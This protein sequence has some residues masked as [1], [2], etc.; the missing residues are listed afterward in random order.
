MTDRKYQF[1]PL[2]T[3][4]DRLFGRWVD[5][6]R[7]EVIREFVWVWLVVSV[8]YGTRFPAETRPG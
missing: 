1:E 4:P 7:G 3:Q 6:D 5:G 2:A 8:L